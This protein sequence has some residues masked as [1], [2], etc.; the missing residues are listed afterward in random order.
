MKHSL[1]AALF[2]LIGFTLF[3]Q[4]KT[5][6]VQPK[7][8][9]Y[10]ISRQYGISQDEL[11]NANPFLKQRELQI[12]DVLVIPGNREENDGQ[13][14]PAVTEPE[15]VFIPQEDESFIY[16]EVKPKQTIYSLTKEYDI[17]EAAL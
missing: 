12:G 5:H 6:T 14:V 17:S 13:I 10:G 7:E 16:I 4:Q 2:F 1:L 9:V 11:K 3:A 15:E 8:T